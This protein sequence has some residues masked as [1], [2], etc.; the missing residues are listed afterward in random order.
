MHCG[1][2]ILQTG[3]MIKSLGQYGLAEIGLK[4]ERSFGCLPCLLTKCEGWLEHR[5]DVAARI[6]VWQQRPGKGE[7]RI[8]PHR[9]CQLLPSTESARWCD[10]RSLN[11]SE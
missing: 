9:F 11:L 5:C 7:L 6:V 2:V 10:L 4:S 3:V 8:Q 1:A